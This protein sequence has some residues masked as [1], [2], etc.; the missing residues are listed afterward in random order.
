M[1]NQKKQSAKSEAVK[2]AAKSKEAAK[3]AS[4]VGEA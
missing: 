1:E 2:S 3:P 4:A